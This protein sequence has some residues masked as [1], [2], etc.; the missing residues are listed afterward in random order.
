MRRYW[1]WATPHDRVPM[2]MINQAM[3]DDQNLGACTFNILL[4]EQL[5]R[6]AEPQYPITQ[7]MCFDASGMHGIFANCLKCGTRNFTGT[8]YPHPYTVH[9]NHPF[10]ARLGKCGCV[11]CSGCVE[12][13]LNHYTTDIGVP[14]PNCRIDNA[15][16]RATIYWIM[17]R[18][19]MEEFMQGYNMDDLL[20]LLGPRPTY[21]EIHG[22]ESSDS[23]NIESESEHLHRE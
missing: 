7:M 1:P 3:W 14:C 6:P 16:E 21:I 20:R 18:A 11:I 12:N 15:F 22:L 10:T 17:N 13:N 2:W 19:V 23:E 8:N 4:I 5:P 9:T